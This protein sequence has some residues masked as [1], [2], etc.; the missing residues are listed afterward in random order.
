[1]AWLKRPLRFK[2]LLLIGLPLLAGA[3]VFAFSF[4]DHF[5]MTSDVLDS[6]GGASASANFKVT[7]A[8]GQ[9]SAAGESTSTHYAMRA[10]FVYTLVS[11]IVPDVATGQGPGAASFVRDFNALNASLLSTFKAFGG[12]NASGE[13]SVAKGDVTGDEAPEI[14]VGQRSMGASSYVRVFKKDG[15]LLWTFKAFGGGNLNGIV[16]VAV[17]DVDIDGVGEII[18]GQGP[19]GDSYVRV[20]EYKNPTPVTTWKAFGGG[21]TSGE[22]RVAAG[23]IRNGVSVGQIITGQ[24]HG[25]QSFVRV[26]DYGT[27]KPTL[28]K[29][30]KSFGPGNTSGGVDVGVGNFDGDAS[31]RYLI[32]VGQGGPGHTAAAPA[33]SYI[34]VFTEDGTLRK[35]RKAF[36]PGNVNGRVTVSG[37]QADGDTADE[38]IVGQAVGGNSFWRAFNYD[39][40]LIRTVKA[41]GGGNTNGQVDVAG[42]K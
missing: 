39:G 15:T 22:V 40:S 33:D 19:G 35:T 24:G 27:P 26:W 37:G 30:F 25:G 8:V 23:Q 1:M 34:R 20:F 42:A 38:I 11:L 29:T 7:D 3:L 17:G 2:T 4:S 6:A 10:G 5:R 13:L 18:V 36:G 31:G 12:G 21:N 9:P 32:V 41:F 28:H 14:V 16:N